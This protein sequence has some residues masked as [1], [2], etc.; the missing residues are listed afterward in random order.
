[1]NTVLASSFYIR[2]KKLPLRLTGDKTS[3]FVPRE[4][5]FGLFT[6]VL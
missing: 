1:M 5:T 4:P 6:G 3:L 2:L